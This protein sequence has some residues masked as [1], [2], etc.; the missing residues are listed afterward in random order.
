MKHR[1]AA[2]PPETSTR[3]LD[4]KIEIAAISG[5]EYIAAIAGTRPGAVSGSR[6]EPGDELPTLRSPE[7]DAGEPDADQPLARPERC[8]VEAVVQER[9]LDHRDLQQ[10]RQGDRTPEEAVG[11]QAPERARP[12]GPG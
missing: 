5:A 6:S 12:V 8:R 3:T 4:P 2:R 10:R 9:Q 1:W 11:E 7:D